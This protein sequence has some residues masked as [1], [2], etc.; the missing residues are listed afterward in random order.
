M[1]RARPTVRTPAPRRTRAAL[2]RLDPGAL[3]HLGP[4]GHFALE[5]LNRAIAAS[6][7]APDVVQRLRALGYEPIGGTPE[8][9]SA[10]I[11]ADIA[12]YARIVKT[13]GITIDP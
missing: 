9:F 4:F 12:N 6:L 5:L 11:T 7:K 10:T 13:A 3:R 2:L 1:R 8:Q